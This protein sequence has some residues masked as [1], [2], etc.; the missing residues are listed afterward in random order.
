MSP[1]VRV[2][3]TVVG[4]LAAAAGV[5]VS[6][7]MLEYCNNFGQAWQFIPTALGMFA[8]GCIALALSPE[9]DDDEDSEESEENT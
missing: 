3:L 1:F 9:Q 6:G 7:Q 5:F 2:L 8:G 4:T